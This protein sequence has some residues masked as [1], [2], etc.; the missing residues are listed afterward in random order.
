M[1]SESMRAETAGEFG[2]KA[3]VEFLKKKKYKII[4]TNF[5]CNFGEIDIIASDKKELVFVEVKTRRRT[6]H[7]NP[8]EFVD[9][10]KLSRMTRTAELFIKLYPSGLSPRF[11]VIEVI[12]GTNGDKFETLS[13]NHIKGIIF[14]SEA[15]LKMR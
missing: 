7:G 9:I 1:R 14:D 5:S 4:T 6:D 12:I 13:I 11:D 2:E 10:R 8:S 3:C 15:A